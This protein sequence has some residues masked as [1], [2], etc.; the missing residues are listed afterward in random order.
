VKILQII[1]KNQLRGA[2]VFACQLSE[3]LHARGHEVVMVT[4][5]DGA[6][7]LPFQ[8]RLYSLKGVPQRRLWD[9]AAW[10]TLAR[11]IAREQPDLI[12]ANAGDTLKYVACSKLFFRWKTPVIFRNASTTSLYI[13]SFGVRQ[14]NRLLLRFVRYVISVSEFTQRDFVKI[15]P[16][17]HTRIAAVPIG[18]VELPLDKTE[19]V[20]TGRPFFIHIGG[21]SYEK[22][23][24]GLIAIFEKIKKLC[25]TATLGL[26]GEGPLKAKV[27]TWVREA[28]LTASVVF[29]GHQARPMLFLQQ[30]DALLLPSVIEGLPSVIL[31]AFYVRVPV[32]AYNAGGISEIV[33]PSETGRLIEV[34]NEE[35]FAQAAVEALAPTP[36]NLQLRDNAFRLVNERYTMKMVADEF[37]KIYTNLMTQKESA[38]K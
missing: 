9:V 38:G 15:F 18:I 16:A 23:H 10:K 26:M 19:F 30:A 28:G 35:A 36:Q 6:V 31:E 34:G 32:I 2:E 37:E 29:F 13:K 27:E 21:F 20:P 4:V 24:K 17:F 33:R 3:E 12:Q 14:W 22:N 11:I 8:G 5:F 25:P 7:K 1:Q